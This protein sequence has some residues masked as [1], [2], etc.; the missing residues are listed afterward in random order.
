MAEYS[1]IEL[2]RMP[3]HRDRHFGAKVQ[4]FNAGCEKVRC[5]N[6]DIIGNLDADITF[7]KDYFEFLLAKFSAD[8]ETWRG[9]N[10]VCGRD[11][12]VRF[13]IYGDGTR[14]WCMS[15]LPTRKFRRDWWLRAR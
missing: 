5:E 3:E 8:A 2:V 10:P 1:W 12:L 14:F 7:G 4:C 11:D 15:V 6:F 9:R 13:S